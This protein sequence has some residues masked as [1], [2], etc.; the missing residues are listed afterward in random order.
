MTTPRTASR[1]LL[2]LA[3]AALLAGVLGGCGS[4]D[5]ATATDSPASGTPSE[6]DSGASA[7]T[8]PVEP[9]T[10]PSSEPT[11]PSTPAVPAG[12]RACA[13][14][15]VD[16]AR[17]PRGYQ[18]CLDEAGGF[19]KADRLGCSSGQAL[20]RFADRFYGVAGGTVRE[21]TSPLLDDPDYTETVENCR[22]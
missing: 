13:E 20:I 7:T 17:I 1:P 6:I 2:G 4:D 14:V 16:E 9:S 21:G 5:D 10:E 18:G 3:V 11:S 12:T 19:V 8:A 15:W 22:A